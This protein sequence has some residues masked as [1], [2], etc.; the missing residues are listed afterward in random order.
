MCS[1]TGLNCILLLLF[2]GV[3]NLY[4]LSLTMQG[5]R[6]IEENNSLCVEDN[7]CRRSA[8][9]PCVYINVHGDQTTA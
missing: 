3:F 7:A 1:D 6:A 9:V 4:L 8:V 2:F 5:A